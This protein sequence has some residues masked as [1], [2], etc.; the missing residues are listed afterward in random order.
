MRGRTRA[1]PGLDSQALRHS[2]RTAVAAVASLLAAHLFRLPE[3]YWAVVTTLI[4]MQSDAGAAWR[5]SVRRFTGTALGALLAA[6]LATCF[7]PSVFAFGAGIFLLGVLCS[8]LGRADRRLPEYLDQTAYRYGGIALAIVLLVVRQEAAWVV[9][10]HRF[11]EV[12]V[13]IAAGLAVTTLWPE[14]HVAQ[15]ASAER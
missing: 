11:V 5:V 7:R 8:L 15:S 14:R 6:P 1:L 12:S 10:L 3:A 4:V 2:A 13:G 9:A